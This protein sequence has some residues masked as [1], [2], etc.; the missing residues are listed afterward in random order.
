MWVT[1]MSVS[2]SLPG[3]YFSKPAPFQ[4]KPVMKCAPPAFRPVLKSMLLSSCNSLC[5]SFA[6]VCLFPAGSSPCNSAEERLCLEA[7]LKT[8]CVDG[9]SRE[10]TGE[11][12][13]W[14]HF[15]SLFFSL[16]LCCRVKAMPSAMPPSWPRPTTATPGERGC[17]LQLSSAR[18][19][20]ALTCCLLLSQAGATALAR[21]TE[22]D[23]C[24]TNHGGF[25]F[26]QLCPYQ[27][28]A[29]RAGWAEGLS[30]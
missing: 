25:P 13:P 22:W 23:Q 24:C 20:S 27:G 26:C 21:E 28:T 18:A 11:A 4:P 6:F 15:T 29:V 19:G 14:F 9:G 8:P 10:L 12:F 2:C 7:A 3:W 16:A 5:F 17:L 30:H 1:R